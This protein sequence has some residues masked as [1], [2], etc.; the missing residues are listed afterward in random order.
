MGHIVKAQTPKHRC[1][2]RDLVQVRR[3]RLFL[4]DADCLL[5]LFVTF[6]MLLMFCGQWM[7]SGRPG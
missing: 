1:A 3:R 4:N 2:K 5:P 7:E 6:K